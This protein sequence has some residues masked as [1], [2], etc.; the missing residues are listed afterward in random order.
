MVDDNRMGLTA[1]KAVFEELG[2]EVDTVST[3]DEA[4]E[5]A[6]GGDFDVLIT[7]Y[8]MTTMNGVDLIKKLREK[9]SKTPVILLSGFVEALGLSEANTGADAVIQKSANELSHLVRAVK[10][11]L[12]PARKPPSSGGAPPSSR[13]KKA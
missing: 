1:R 13:R 8:R 5:R 3:P 11:L 12:K 4:L 2:F 10:T 9:E 7:D 6:A